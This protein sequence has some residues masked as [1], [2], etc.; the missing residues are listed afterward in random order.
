M[1]P[2]FWAKDLLSRPS[3]GGPAGVLLAPLALAGWVYGR[4]Q[5][6]RRQAYRRGWLPSV[7]VSV[8]V[9]SVGNVTAGGTGKTPCVQTVCRLLQQR[10]V[11]PAV[12]SR[13]YGGSLG[14]AVAAV[15]DGEQVLLGPDQAGD[16]PV[17]LA[18]T[19]P[20][21]PV[22]VG[23]R[24]SQSA[25]LAIEA[26]G[27]EVLVLDDGFQ[28]LRLARDL[29]LVMVD[30][31]VPFA[32][33]HCFPRGLLRESPRALRAADLVVLTRTRR[34]EP[35]RIEATRR[36]VEVYLDGRPVLT[37]A[38]L[39]VALVDLA[40]GAVHPLERLAGLKI[41]AA[42]GIGQPEL[43]FQDLKDLGAE[44]LQTVPYPDHHRF[45]TQEVTQLDQ[46]AGLMRADAVVTTEKDGVR[47]RQFLPLSVPVLALRIEVRVSD[48]AVLE[49]ALDSLLEGRRDGD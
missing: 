29:D 5:A 37:A 41:L 1:G 4:V 24:R 30:A 16:E 40:N 33:G 28:H 8:P 31:R 19:L 26:L 21:V 36:E 34:V 6:V 7:R 17:L 18:N 3:A 11:R 14:G 13:G 10:C 23:A 47:L 38:H 20:G 46:W 49:R 12:L 39:P 35:R 44:V 45:S 22:V 27:A 9:V 15:S 25:R 32:N 42:A 2:Y 43:F 48:P